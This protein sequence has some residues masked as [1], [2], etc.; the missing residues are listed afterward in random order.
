MKSKGKSKKTI[1]YCGRQNFHNTKMP[2]RDTDKNKRID[3]PKVN[4]PKPTNSK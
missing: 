3:D 1:T 4:T 2:N